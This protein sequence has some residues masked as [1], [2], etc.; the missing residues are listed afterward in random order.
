MENTLVIIDFLSHAEGIAWVNHP[1]LASHRDH[2]L[3]HRLLPRGAG[4][5]VTFG[6]KG[7]RD[8][9]R[10]F[11]DGL[12][13]VSHLA[14]VGDAKTLIIHPASTTHQQLD[15]AALE[16]AGVGEDLIRISVGLEDPADII[17]DLSQ[18]LRQ[19]L[20]AQRQTSPGQTPPGQAPLDSAAE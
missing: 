11:V 9:G 6:L 2:A 1:S 4:S 17:A 3:A 10:R 16:A 8:A 19:A 12:G 18:A 20:K 14:N 7:G 13:L 15:A 5:I